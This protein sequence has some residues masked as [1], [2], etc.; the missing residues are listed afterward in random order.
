MGQPTHAKAS[1]WVRASTAWNY[2]LPL[3]FDARTVDVAS[4]RFGQR[5]V[6]FTNLGGSVEHQG[7]G[8]RWSIPS[9]P[10]TGPGRRRRSPGPLLRTGTGLNAGDTEGCVKGVFVALGGA[11]FKFFGCDALRLVP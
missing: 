3:D 9:N 10:T 8:A 6:V 2:G 7:R 5:D 11:R 4:L 1:L